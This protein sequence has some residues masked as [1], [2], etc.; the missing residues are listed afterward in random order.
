MVDHIIDNKEANLMMVFF[1]SPVKYF[2]LPNEHQSFLTRKLAM[3]YLP[4]IMHVQLTDI[5]Q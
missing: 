3:N 1:G 5:Q 4:Q 2:W